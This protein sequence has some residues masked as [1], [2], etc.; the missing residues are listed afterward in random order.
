MREQARTVSAASLV[1]VAELIDQQAVGRFQIGVLLL[2]AS[3]MLVDGFDTQAIG[4]VA[5]ALSVALA[6]K[7]AALGLVFAAGGLGAIL[8][9]L[10]LSAYADR[11]GRKPIIVGSMLFFAVCTLLISTASTVPQL[12]WMR[13]AIGLGLG[14]VVPNALALS[15]EFMPKK[16]RVTLVLMT[17]LGFSIGSGVAGPVTAYILVAHSWRAVFLFAGILP[18]V[19]A[20]LLI[21]R[22][23]ESL[24]GL[25]QRGSEGGRIATTLAQ[26]NAN[27]VFPEDARFIN[28]EK[29]EKGF[30]V[31]L[32]FREGR[33]RITLLLWVMFFMNLLAI[34]FLNSWLPT[35]L[36]KAG[37][38][39]HLAIV[40]AALLHFGGIAGGL[41]IAPLCDKFNPYVV[42]AFAYILSGTFIAGIGISRNVALFA[43]ATT[44]FAGFFTFGA[45]NT[46]NAIAA[47]RYPTAMRSSG[48]GWALGIGR[49]GQ[50]V[51][52]LIGGFLLSL[53][54]GT[55]EILYVIAVPSVVAA[56]VALFLSS[57]SGQSGFG[58]GAEA[59][60]K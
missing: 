2:C 23:P 36:H 21:W 11:V 31:A 15:A 7:P 9:G 41:A 30:P 52:P 6:V 33:A 25:T 35:V 56:T 26:M 60:A 58:T 5:P 3:A 45:Q 37:L 47:I 39:Q 46:A 22:L 34:F 49:I 19:L 59:V 50:I 54:W 28:S 17:W 51:G 53:Q 44:F 57:A 8:G 55:T 10:A 40:I 12:M 24:Q 27:L 48:I 32:L 38:P 20:P 29:K 16:F 13:F 14:G 42:L 43:M 18:V 4:Y 1:D